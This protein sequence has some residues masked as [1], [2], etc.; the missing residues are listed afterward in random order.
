MRIQTLLAGLFVV[1]VALLLI[2]LRSWSREDT[3]ACDRDAKRVRCVVTRDTWLSSTIRSFD[4]IADIGTHDVDR[5]SWTVTLFDRAGHHEDVVEELD[6]DEA[7]SMVTW[8]GQRGDHMEVARDRYP[9]RQTALMIV[10]VVLLVGVAFGIRVDRRVRR[11]QD[12][13]SSNREA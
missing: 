9:L 2:T 4:D 3:V 10:Y 5:G 8:F 13:E 12:A 1:L 6:E 7:K 11:R